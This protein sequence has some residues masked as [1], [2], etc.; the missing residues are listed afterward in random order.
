LAAKEGFVP[1]PLMDLWGPVPLFI[2][3]SELGSKR[4]FYDAFRIRVLFVVFAA[5]W[6][7]SGL[8]SAAPQWPQAAGPNHDFTVKTDD[9]VPT[10]WS[11]QREENIL[12][13]TPLPETGQSGIAIW[14]DMI[15][16]TTMK[17]LP[18]GEVSDKQ[19]RDGTDI[20]MFCF[21]ANT[22]KQRWSK[23]LLGD[24]TA[25]S[26]YGYGFSSSSSPTPITDGKHVW[27][28][29]A[30][31]RMGCW[32]VDGEEVWTRRWTPTLGR[33]FNKQFEPI[34][35]GDTVLN[36]EPLEPDNPNRKKD[37]WNYVRGFDAKTG[38]LKWTASEGV[39][40][41]NTPVLG[42]LPNGG[43]AVLSGRGAH[44]KP[45]EAPAG[46]TLTYADGDKAGETVWNWKTLPDGKTMATQCWNETYSYWLDETLTDFIVLHT[47][48]GTE[49]KR[50]SL[51]RDVT[52]TSY[53]EQTR[54][55]TSKTGVNLDEIQPKMTVF[56]AWYANIDV[57]PYV[58]FQC[59]YYQGKRGK[60]TVNLGP[61]HSIARINVET[62]T[63]EYLQIPFPTPKI[64]GEKS[65]AWG[66][67][68]PEM[69]NNSR[70]IDVAGDKRSKRAGW[71]WCFNGN[72][73]AVNQY[74]YFTFMCGRV[75]VIDGS[76]ATF[77][78]SA[79]VALNDLG[80]FGETW[81]A[82]TPSYSNGKLYHRT[83]K[84]LICI[85]GKE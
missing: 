9:D 21:D 74:L 6:G 13:R 14:E 70:G 24:P 17:P 63:V 75:Q 65:M 2:S 53:D 15:F 80:K 20:V 48:D 11:V 29:N 45:P 34:K 5:T 23:E 64:R 12:W 1:T 8:T 38:T 69:T 56:P 85:G 44:H 66:L 77:D 7:S 39:T 58:Y 78:Q 27:F 57:Y 72:T 33:P 59:F 61:K 35:V 83:M 71:Y 16:L 82:N 40:H 62:A 19:K 18:E 79:L 22:G 81:S 28:Y 67:H 30:S 47:T 42:R 50:I 31:G 76:A 54:A 25:P 60:R 52:V 3:I 73:I 36:V 37:P 68:Y 84:E 10:T 43:H 46:L 49:A 41:Y 51:V 32:T 4:M 26:I 55:F